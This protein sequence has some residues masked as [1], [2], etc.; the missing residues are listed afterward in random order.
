MLLVVAVMVTIPITSYADERYVGLSDENIERYFGVDGIIS[1]QEQANAKMINDIYLTFD[2]TSLIGNSDIEEFWEDEVIVTLIGPTDN[3][4]QFHF[5]IHDKFLQNEINIREKLAKFYPEADYTLEFMSVSFGEPVTMDGTNDDSHP[6][7]IEK[8][9]VKRSAPVTFS[10]SQTVNHQLTNG[11]ITS[12]DTIGTTTITTPITVQSITVTLTITH[13]DH[14]EMRSYLKLSDDTKVK[15]FDRPR[16]I[17]DGIHTYTLTENNTPG[18]QSLVGRTVQDNITLLVGDYYSG[19][20]DGTVISWAI[21]IIGVGSSNTQTGTDSSTPDVSIVAQIVDFFTSFFGD[22]RC[23]FP[24]DDCMPKLAGMKHENIFDGNRKSVATLNIGG[25]ETTD[26]KEGFVVAG[27]VAKP[28]TYPT[29]HHYVNLDVLGNLVT[30]NTLGKVVVNNDNT[31][32][33]AFVEYP[34]KC[35]SVDSTLN[36]CIGSEF[37]APTVEKKIY[38]GSGSSYNVTDSA[39]ILSGTN[40]KWFGYMTGSEQSGRIVSAV[41]FDLPENNEGFVYTVIMM[42]GRESV[43]KDSGAPVY[44]VN[45]NGDA[46]IVGLITAHDTRPQ[47]NKVFVTPWNLIQQ[48][49]GLKPIS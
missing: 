5:A 40:V 19:R 15:L 41:P 12:P 1:T 39:T 3:S 7:D 14:D 16:K 45:S 32:D 31:I 42:D 30:K 25:L 27:H 22:N 28:N 26:G 9:R 38:R 18:L 35:D 2:D 48:D 43:D 11:R 13:E 29:I 46:E 44:I 37:Y 17:P 33:A 23:D 4:E 8:S 47:Y 36:T 6:D 49:L 24:G 21:N 20:D 34:L 10:D